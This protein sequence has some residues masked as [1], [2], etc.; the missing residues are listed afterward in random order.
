MVKVLELLE[1]SSSE[2][3]FGVGVASQEVALWKGGGVLASLGHPLAHKCQVTVRVP[4]ACG[5]HPWL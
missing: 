5:R 2:G 3:A 1:R 4:L